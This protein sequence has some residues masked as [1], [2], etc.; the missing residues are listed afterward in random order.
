MD[1]S[2]SWVRSRSHLWFQR[3]LHR[4]TPPGWCRGLACKHT[5][6]GIFSACREAEHSFLPYVSIVLSV[7]VKRGP[8]HWFM[9]THWA[10]FS[11]K[12]CSNSWP[13]SSICCE[14]LIYWTRARTPTPTSTVFSSFMTIHTNTTL[15]IS[16]VQQK[17]TA[18]D[19]RAEIKCQHF[20]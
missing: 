3:G 19:N 17:Q 16:V 12:T 9:P 11:G 5:R 8:S 15:H 2:R 1:P 4:Q 13:F 10:L 20:K 7:T 6:D 14:S 18:R